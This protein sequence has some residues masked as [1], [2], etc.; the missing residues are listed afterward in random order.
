MDPEVSFIIVSFNTRDLLRD[1]LKCVQQRIDGVTNEIFVVDNGSSDGSANMVLKEFPEVNLLRSIKNLGFGAA[2]NLALAKARGHVI[3]FLN[4]DAFPHSQ[5]IQ[6]GLKHLKSD[7]G[8][9]GARLVSADGSWQPSARLFPSPLNDFLILSG[10]SFRYPKSPFFGRPDRTF[11]PPDEPC[12]TDWVPGAFA[13]V[14]HPVLK[15][16]GGFDER[17]FLYYEE[18]DLCLRIKAAGYRIQYWPDVVVTHLGGAS[19]MKVA[20]EP[21]CPKE[22]QLLLA[23][24]RSKLLYYR[25]HHG[26]WGAWSARIIEE[27]WHLLRLMKNWF[28]P[29]KADESHQQIALMRRAWKETAGG[30]T[31]Q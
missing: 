26:W 10:L 17:F 31:W 2:N 3:A 9:V 18:V 30:T 24:M 8:M 13:L 25:K 27:G 4:S 5:S 16:V 19:A 21:F 20:G 29:R 15:E 11:A 12:D 6:N 22:A 23:R 7:I 14:P 28:H 1:C